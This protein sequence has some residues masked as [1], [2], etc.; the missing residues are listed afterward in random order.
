M[1]DDAYNRNPLVVMILP[2]IREH[3]HGCTLLALVNHCEAALQSRV[4]GSAMSRAFEK[5]FLVM[6][7][8]YQLQHQLL[9][10]HDLYLSISPMD[11]HI[12][13]GTRV[14]GNNDVARDASLASYY[15]DWNNLVQ[16][17]EEDIAELLADFWR[18][19]SSTEKVDWAASVLGVILPLQKD[20]VISAY[21]ARASITH[22]DKGGR[23]EDFVDVRQ[24]YEILLAQCHNDG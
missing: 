8:L 18:R 24:A 7:G 2:Y 15:L 11:I 19:V 17:T 20:T 14:V 4:A 21:R 16:T 13:L 1:A 3:Q 22:P 12:Q 5:N 23:H 10:E 6:N 9:S